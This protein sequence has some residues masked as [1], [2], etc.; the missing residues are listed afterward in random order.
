[1][2][3]MVGK[4]FLLSL[5]LAIATA[6]ACAQPILSTKNKKAIELYTDAD[7][8]RVRGEYDQAMAMLQEAIQ[9][10]KNFS[11]AYFRVALIHKTQ[12]HYDKAISY[13][14]QVNLSNYYIMMPLSLL[15]IMFLKICTKKTAP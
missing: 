10:D 1:M 3:V 15:S 6:V 4:V 12:R 7:N 13:Y 8:F 11:E 5:V 9:R 14:H 2:K